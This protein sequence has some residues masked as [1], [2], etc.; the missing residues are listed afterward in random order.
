MREKIKKSFVKTQTECQL[1]GKNVKWTS[2]CQKFTEQILQWSGTRKTTFCT[3]VF[4]KLASWNFFS[5]R[6]FMKIENEESC[7]VLCYSVLRGWNIRS[8]CDKNNFWKK[9]FNEYNF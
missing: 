8:K 9:K 1:V 4:K 2:S 5:F 6:F 3:E 7:G